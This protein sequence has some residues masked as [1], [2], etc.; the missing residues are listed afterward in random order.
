MDFCPHDFQTLHNRVVGLENQNRRL[1]QLGLAALFGAALFL[2]MGQGPTKKTVEANEFVLRDRNGDVR[3]RLSIP[4]EAASVVM[5]QMVFLDAKG[6]TSLELD[7]GIAGSV[8]GSVGI[9]DEQ[10]KRV[11]G[12]ASS[13]DGGTVWVRAKG[14]DSSASFLHPGT[15]DVS[16]DQGFEATVGTAHLVTPTTGE[17]HTTSAASL[18]MFDKG[19]N[20]I[21]KAP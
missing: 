16:D 4:S 14:K 12:L 10:G 8:G 13:F 15:V 20:L 7:G 5:P 18:V 9:N 1:K 6:N 2:L 17:T 21:W 3:V 11:A 19:K